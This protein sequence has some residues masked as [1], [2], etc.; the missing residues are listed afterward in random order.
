L[1]RPAI[2]LALCCFAFP[3]QSADATPDATVKYRHAVMKGM[4]DHLKALSMINKGE[5]PRP[6]D[7][8]F[9]AAAIRD[10]SSIAGELFP[11]GT[12]PDKIKTHAKPEVWTKPD[13]FKAAMEALRTQAGAL[14]DLAKGTDTAAIAAQ[15]GKVGEACGKCHDDFRVDD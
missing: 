6:Q 13:E 10:A 8:A 9:H 15:F 7:I 5:M 12:G 3:A 4:G 2:L 11:A 14:V 1:R